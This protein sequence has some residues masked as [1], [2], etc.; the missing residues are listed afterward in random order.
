M[1]QMGYSMT[2]ATR[3]AQKMSPQQ[4]MASSLL[5]ATIQDLRMEVRQRLETNPAIEDVKWRDDPLLSSVIGDP[6]GGKSAADHDVPL[7]FTPDGEAASRMLSSEDG[8]TDEFLGNMESAS[9]DD[10]DERR[11]SAMRESRSK[12]DADREE[13][14]QHLF[15]SAVADETLETHLG[16]QIMISDFTA[17]ERE[18]AAIVVGNLDEDGYFIGS[19]PDIVMASHV[20]EQ[21][22]ISVQQRI[23]NTFDPP[24]IAARNLRECLLAQMERFDDSPWEDEVRAVVER[25]LDDLVAGRFEKVRCA[26]GLT[27][28]E[29]ERLMEQF[30]LFN[31]KPALQRWDTPDGGA[32]RHVGPSTPIYIY[33]EIHAVKKGGRWRAVVTDGA[34]PKIVIS[35]TYRN[36]ADDE[37]V[38][39]EA[40]TT[41][42]NYVRD[43]EMLEDLLDDRQEK[44]RRV[45]Q[46]IID[47][48]P[49]FFEKGMAG[50]RPLSQ[51]TIAERVKLDDSTVSRAVNGK[52]MTT[53]FGTVELRSLFASGIATE[54]GVVTPGQAKA[55][56]RALIAAEDPSRPLSDDAIASKLKAEGF[57]LSRRTVAKYRDAE[58]IPGSSER[59]VR[60]K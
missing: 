23:C 18:L 42:R 36:M 50:L 4:Y 37:S 21:A 6:A 26:L 27:E 9:S 10:P 7:D 19:I 11:L 13:R 2:Q 54:S 25:H 28:E 47:A 8:R 31:R 15:D 49:D 55:R 52:Y 24:G 41:I 12:M 51:S 56:I 48:Q 45:A 46:A 16:R 20:D 38:P 33:P 44:M 40:R 30:A 32:G 53:P 14:R 17:E 59:R 29:W 22:L 1:P 3:L 60:K 39:R 58:G 35:S 34:I 57:H 43:A 5:Q